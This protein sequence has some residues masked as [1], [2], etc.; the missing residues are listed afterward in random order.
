MEA[1]QLG[2]GSTGGFINVPS[3]VVNSA[4]LGFVTVSAGFLRHA[5]LPRLERLLLGAAGAQ[6]REWRTAPGE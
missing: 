6:L 4:S 2:V 1:S 5:P 3:P